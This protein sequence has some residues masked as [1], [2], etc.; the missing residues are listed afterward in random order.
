MKSRLA[1]KSC[2]LQA[3]LSHLELRELVVDI[4][5]HQRQVKQV[6]SGLLWSCYPEMEQKS[7]VHKTMQ[8]NKERQNRLKRRREEPL[9]GFLPSKAN[10]LPEQSEVWLVAGQT[11]HNLQHRVKDR[12]NLQALI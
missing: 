6:K 7:R 11:Q 9:L 1:F 8:Q 10:F 3:R 5:S 12:L 4:L 2:P